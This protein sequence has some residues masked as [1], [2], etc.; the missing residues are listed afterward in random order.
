MA[1]PRGV[2][3][4]P[5]TT[6]VAITEDYAA[7]SL[8]AALLFPV[9]FSNRVDP[10]SI[11][12]DGFVSSLKPRLKGLRGAGFERVLKIRDKPLEFTHFLTAE[13]HLAPINEG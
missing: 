6:T 1:Y 12:G 8:A 9:S 7:A 13:T 5:H 4:D 3:A 11:T 2:Q 10:S